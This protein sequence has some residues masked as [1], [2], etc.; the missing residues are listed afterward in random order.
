LQDDQKQSDDVTSDVNDDDDSNKHFVF[1]DIIEHRIVPSG[2]DFPDHAIEYLTE[3]QN[4][5]T[6]W[7]REMCFADENGEY[8]IKYVE[9]LVHHGIRYA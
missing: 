9:Y 2:F 1:V 3:F 4:G 7:L 5:E 8:P 6:L